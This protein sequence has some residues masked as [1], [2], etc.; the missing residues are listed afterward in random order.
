M[1]KRT[2]AIIQARMAASRLP[3]KVLL[4]IGGQPMLTRVVERTRR[5][6]LVDEVVVATTVEPSD[7]AIVDFCAQHGYLCTRGSLNDVLDRYYQ[8][9]RQ[10]HANV[11]VRITA[12][13]PVIDPTLID[14]AVQAF[15]GKSPSKIQNHNS[16]IRFDFVANRLPPPWKRTYPIGLDTEVTSFQ[17]LKLAWQNATQAYQREHVMPYFYEKAL[18]IDSLSGQ[19]IPP[20]YPE[21]RFTVLYLNHAPDYGHYRWTVDTPQDLEA[22]RQ[23]YA[24]FE[25]RDDFS[26]RDILALYQRDPQLFEINA[27]VHHKSFLDV[28][29]RQA[30]GDR[31]LIAGEENQ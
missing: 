6:K 1:K 21:A 11:V 23:I 26:W 12:D 17:H 29:A 4:D 24:R 14:E 30:G 27:D 2:L 10:H 28:D 15:L 20:V 9:A 22:L 18:V 5:A 16:N 7:D 19:P 13:C 31:K 8:A 25:G 3:G